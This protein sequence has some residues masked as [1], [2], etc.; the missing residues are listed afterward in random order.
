MGTGSSPAVGIAFLDRICARLVRP[1]VLAHPLHER[2]PGVC[3]L[4][5]RGAGVHTVWLRTAYKLV[6]VEAQMPVTEHTPQ[7]LI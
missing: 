2:W 3:N 1:P 7:R 5:R 4:S 6:L